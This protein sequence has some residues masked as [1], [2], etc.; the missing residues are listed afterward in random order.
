MSEEE[1]AVA[2]MTLDRIANG[3]VTEKISR[4]E[5]DDLLTHIS[6]RDEN[7]TIEIREEVTDEE[8]RKFLTAATEK[9]DAA[10]VPAEVEPS[11]ELKKI[12]DAALLGEGAVVDGD[13]A[14]ENIDEQPADAQ[15]AA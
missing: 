13:A 8:L 11:D 2:K 14:G 4:E 12:I 7:G 1:K 5:L 15:D 9:A 10:G 3:I 6:D